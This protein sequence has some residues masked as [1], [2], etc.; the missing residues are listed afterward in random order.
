MQLH[1]I[2]LNAP[3][4]ITYYVTCNPVYFV[5]ENCR[6]GILLYLHDLAREA[7]VV[8]RREGSSRERANLAAAALRVLEKRW[9]V[10]KTWPVRYADYCAVASLSLERV[11]LLGLALLS[12]TVFSLAASCRGSTLLRRRSLSSFNF[13]IMHQ[14][15]I[16][17]HPPQLLLDSAV[18]ISPA[19]G[20]RSARSPTRAPLHAGWTGRSARMPS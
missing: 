18:V 12:A 15:Q 5:R 9:A 11:E 1:H 19:G 2:F 17:G 3:S 20:R 6:S 14:C 16:L 4:D 13:Y 10:E 7:G 8:V